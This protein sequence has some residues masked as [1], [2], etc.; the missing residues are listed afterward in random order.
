MIANRFEIVEIFCIFYSGTKRW[1]GMGLTAFEATDTTGL[2]R[3]SGSQEDELR[4]APKKHRPTI[5]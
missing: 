1:K 4:V 5:A 3:K 2:T